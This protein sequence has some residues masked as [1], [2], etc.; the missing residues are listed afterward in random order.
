MKRFFSDKGLHS[1]T[2]MLAEKHG[3]TT[4]NKEIEDNINKNFIDITKNSEPKR[5]LIHAS[6]LLESLIHVF[7]HIDCFQRI[8]LANIRD[9]EQFHFSKITKAEVKKEILSL[10]SKNASLKSDIP[11]KILKD[12]IE[13]IIDKLTNLLNY[14]LE[15]GIVSTELR[16][17]NV[18]TIFEKN[19]HR[20][21]S[22][23]PHLS[24]DYIIRARNSWF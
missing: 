13:F 2:T 24:K 10:S 4:D 11:T 8:K 7:R 9:N 3:T 20:P 5:D 14:C 16:L 18:S 12:S 21:V 23:L 15:K 17:A 6:Q 19:Y 22:I 1:N